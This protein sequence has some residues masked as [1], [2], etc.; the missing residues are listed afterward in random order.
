M[1]TVATVVING[2]EPIKYGLVSSTD[3]TGGP[4]LFIGN[5]V[6]LVLCSSQSLEDLIRELECMRDMVCE[7]EAQ[8]RQNEA[9]GWGK[10]LPSGG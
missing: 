7:H 6:T 8:L 4:A 9:I 5:D 2:T 1:R 3:G 10:S